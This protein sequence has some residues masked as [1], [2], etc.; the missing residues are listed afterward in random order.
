M[1]RELLRQ[2]KDEE[3]CFEIEQWDRRAARLVR[4]SNICSS[5]SV[6]SALWLA[7]LQTK[8]LFKGLGLTNFN[9][10]ALKKI[11]DAGANIKTNPVLHFAR[12]WYQRYHTNTH[13]IF[14]IT[15]SCHLCLRSSP[16]SIAA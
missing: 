8:G 2:S 5:L 9:L 12:E 3:V 16:Q 14:I 13:N 15:Y 7:E 6:D 1:L 4:S 11:T 10:K